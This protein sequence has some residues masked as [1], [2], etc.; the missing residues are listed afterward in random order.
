ME[1]GQYSAES[2]PS[3]ETVLEDIN[4][5]NELESYFPPE[6]NIY[7]FAAETYDKFAKDFEEQCYGKTDCLFAF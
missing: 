4:S 3:C 7:D 2:A 6:C 1:F 5:G